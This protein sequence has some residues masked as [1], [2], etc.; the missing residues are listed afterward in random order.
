MQN[1]DNLNELDEVGIVFSFSDEYT[2]GVYLPLMIPLLWPF[3]LTAFKVAKKY[4]FN[5]NINFN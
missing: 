3:L 1:Q 5:L 2:M 4:N